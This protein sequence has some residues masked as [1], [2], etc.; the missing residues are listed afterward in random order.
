MKSQKYAAQG[1]III[2][3]K[4]LSYGQNDFKS[5]SAVEYPTLFSFEVSKSLTVGWGGNLR[6]L[7][8]KAKNL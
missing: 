1:S 5:D 8:G 2:R 6:F 3:D 4:A 7:K